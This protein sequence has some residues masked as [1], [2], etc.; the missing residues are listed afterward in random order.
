[1]KSRLDAPTIKSPTTTTPVGSVQ[2]RDVRAQK[3]DQFGAGGARVDVPAGQLAAVALPGKKS[4][5]VAALADDPAV[6]AL[7]GFTPMQQLVERIGAREYPREAIADLLAAQNGARGASP[8]VMKNIERLRSPDSVTVV[9]G[10]QVGLL[11]GPLYSLFKALGA[12]NEAAALTDRGIDAVPVFWLASYDH[13][14]AEVNH[15]QVVGNGYE[16]TKVALEAES[17]QDLVPVGDQKLGPDIGR[18]LDD[19]EKS[20]PETK[21]KA[22]TMAMLREIYTPDATYAGAFAKFVGRLTDDLGLVILDPNERGFNALAKG[23]LERELFGESSAGALA[24]NAARL[25]ELGYEPQIALRDDRL[26]V[27][28]VDD[29]G[30]RVSLAKKDGGFETGGSP[31][32]LDE[33]TARR[34]LDD[35]PERFSPSALLR[36]VVEDAVLPTVGY[37]GGP[38]EQ[39]YYAQAGAAYAWADVPPPHAL[40]RPSFTVVRAA[41]AKLLGDATDQGLPALLADADPS[42]TVGRAGV[43]KEI[44]VAY[45][46]FDAVAS[47]LEAIGAK[48]PE[49]LE[50]GAQSVSI[51]ELRDLKKSMNTAFTRAS[52]AVRAA[53]NERLERGLPHAQEKATRALD[54]LIEGLEQATPARTPSLGGLGAVMKALNGLSKQ[55]VK[56]GRQE[57]PELVDTLSKLR[58]A[59]RDPQERTMSIAQLLAEVGPDIAKQLLPRAHVRQTGPELI[60]VGKDA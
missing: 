22:A 54:G 19:V 2:G 59:G 15:V 35:A 29:E 34:L 47:R 13:D 11:G 24:A 31:R 52:S 53:G 23:V 48:I 20:L 8:A 17:R 49:R 46:A 41:D 32:F 26:N 33:A 18:F 25:E 6:Q 40:A 51:R 60:V 43:P 55:L 9:T 3:I 21:H 4:P 39:K 42:E 5:L 45:D 50:A 38:S 14:L 10:Q 36:P 58:P 30:R 16:P 56:V 12:V 44:R 27:F 28:F 1:M 37:V 7:Y 57:R